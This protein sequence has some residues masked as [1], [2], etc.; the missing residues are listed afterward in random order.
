MS[1][2]ATKGSFN[3]IKQEL[4]DLPNN[5]FTILFPGNLKM[6]SSINKHLVA[7]VDWTAFSEENL[8]KLKNGISLTLLKKIAALKNATAYKHQNIEQKNKKADV[9]K[10]LT[11]RTVV[12]T[13]RGAISKQLRKTVWEE[14]LDK[15]KYEDKCW[16][17]QRTVINR[18][19]F[20]S[21]HIVAVAKGGESTIS[22]LRPICDG[23]NQDMKDQ[24]MFDYMIACGYEL[25]PMQPK[26]ISP[27]PKELVP[28]PKEIVS[29]SKEI[30]SQSKDIVSQSKDIVSQ[31]KDIG[32]QLKEIV[33]GPKEP[34]P[35]TTF[36]IPLTSTLPD[37][38]FPL[39]DFSH[40]AEIDILRNEI[41]KELSDLRTEIRKELDAIHG[42]LAR[43]EEFTASKTDQKVQ[44]GPKLIDL[45]SGID[46][47]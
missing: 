43:L 34:S 30:V 8:E 32:A 45:L 29:Q 33:A 3:E 6:L 5:V 25:R 4:V 7:N 20:Q 17:C 37:R 22:N 27:Q 14:Y 16:C 18:D 10:F 44:P 35:Q 11:D 23:C 39:I 9:I 24:N 26:E 38:D 47:Y 36:P 15:T 19:H 28:A 1:T 40:S 21:G 13:V 42:R 2:K 31:S 41:K 12:V 46:S